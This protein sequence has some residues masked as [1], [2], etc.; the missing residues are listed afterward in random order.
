MN[1]STRSAAVATTTKADGSATNTPTPSFK[2][3]T[4]EEVVAADGGRSNMETQSNL[5]RIGSRRTVTLWGETEVVERGVLRRIKWGE[6]G[7]AVNASLGLAIYIVNSIVYRSQSTVLFI[8][9]AIFSLF[10]FASLAMVYYKN[11]SFAIA[12]RLFKEIN[13]LIILG[14]GFAIFVIDCTTAYNIFSPFLS[15]IYL[16]ETILFVFLD[17]LKNKSRAF[18]LSVGLL[19]VLLN[20][21]NIFQLVLGGWHLHTVL[22]RYGEGLY[23]LKRPVKRSIFF[24][25]LVFSFQG[26]KTMLK[27]TKMEMMMFATGQ[28]YRKSGTDIKHTDDEEAEDEDLHVRNSVKLLGKEEQIDDHLL[29]RIKW[30]QRG[31]AIFAFIGMLIYFVNYSVPRESNSPSVLL[32]VL[33]FVF[34]GLMFVSL[35]IVYFKNISYSVAK[36]LLAEVNVIAILTLGVCNFVIDLAIPYNSY[37]WVMSLIYLLEVALFLFLD[38]VRHKHRAFVLAVGVLFGCLNVFN[39]CELIFGDYYVGEILFQ[40]SEEHVFYRRSVQRSIFIQIFMFS[41]RGLKIMFKDKKME[42]LMFVHG[43]IYRKTGTSS[44]YVEQESFVK[45]MRCENVGETI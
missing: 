7:V 26:V 28:I 15:F 1:E 9:V 20:V 34:A 41:F 19:F 25:V 10:M 36:K 21:Y 3:K 14:C 6:R 12:R 33:V 29:T 38:A 40:Y 30:G 24:Q 17:A 35:G 45:R 8:G 5:V 16:F 42:L 39:A 22:F 23:F 11:V 44:K 32:N 13:V 18:V 37:S 43:H 31:S 2:E 27:D 4:F